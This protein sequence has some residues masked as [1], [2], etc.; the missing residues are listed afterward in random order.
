M[1]RADLLDGVRFIGRSVVR[2]GAMATADLRP[3]PDVVITG[4]KRGGT[5]SLFRD[6]ERHPAMCPLVP[7]ARRLPLREN[8]KGAHYFDSD[9]HHGPRWYRSHFPTSLTRRWRA[10]QVGAAFTAE[11]S[12][13]Y[14]FHPLAASR[15]AAALSATTF[16]V[17][18][19]DPVERTVSHWAEQTRNGVEALSL[20]D[21]ISAEPAR[22]GT[23]ADQLASGAIG[24]SHAH[25]QQSYASQSEYADSIERWL[26]AVGSDR[27]LVMFAE[28][29]YRDPP[30]VLDRITAALGVDPL[31]LPDGATHR[32][33]APRPSS[34]DRDLEQTLVDRFAPDVARVAELVGR[35]PP[36]PRFSAAGRPSTG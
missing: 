6:L 10:R 17:L 7:S 1:D 13:Y 26:G 21:A 4:V 3:E 2:M 22:L 11:A 18:L 34:I 12:P 5:T 8:M 24:A 9:L 32:N 35:E 25:E 36:W 29:Y 33:A 30:S 31:P 16:V 14:L 19:R 27:L 23:A 15:A 28:D 20:A